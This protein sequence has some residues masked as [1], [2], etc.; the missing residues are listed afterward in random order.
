MSLLRPSHTDKGAAHD[1]QKGEGAIGKVPWGPT[2]DHR[3]WEMSD[4]MDNTLNQEALSAKYLIDAHNVDYLYE[5]ISPEL[6]TIAIA[7]ARSSVKIHK[8]AKKLVINI[9][10]RDIT[11]CRAATNSWLR[12]AL[13][14]TDVDEL[15]ADTL[16][17]YAR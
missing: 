5:S 12:L 11:S 15:V 7:G 8:T 2:T 6:E 17:E 1:H 10:A 14:A 4:I 3:T 9:K 16:E 13:I